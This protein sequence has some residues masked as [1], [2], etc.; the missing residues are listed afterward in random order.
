MS[1]SSFWINYY[2]T[3]FITEHQ[4][5]YDITTN[6]DWCLKLITDNFIFVL[7]PNCFLFVPQKSIQMKFGVVITNNIETTMNYTSQ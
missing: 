2:E 5:I 1:D 3:Q 6:I 7:F 4:T